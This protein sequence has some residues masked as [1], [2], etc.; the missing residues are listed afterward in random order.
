MKENLIHDIIGK[1]VKVIGPFGSEEGFVAHATIERGFT[2]LAPDGKRKIVCLNRHD[3]GE[4]S[5][6]QYYELLDK[7]VGEIKDD[8]AL[9]L[10]DLAMN[11]NS[12]PNCA[13]K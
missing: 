2:I 7:I 12:N 11:Y 4:G 9:T 8:G 13:F 10:E 5:D 3:C 1:E 6:Q